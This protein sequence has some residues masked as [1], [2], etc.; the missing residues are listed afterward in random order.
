ML[1]ASLQALAPPLPTRVTDMRA[2]SRYKQIGIPVSALQARSY[3]CRAWSRYM[4]LESIYVVGDDTWGW[5]SPC[6]SRS[7]L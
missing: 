1:L 6:A 7:A 4:W 2:Y 3:V 5:S